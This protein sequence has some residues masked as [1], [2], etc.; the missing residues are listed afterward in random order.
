LSLEAWVAL[1]AVDVASDARESP[2]VAFYRGN[3][4]VDN[5]SRGCSAA[6]TSD[7][8]PR[9]LEWLRLPGDLE[10]IVLGAVPIALAMCRGYVALW[11]R[12]DLAVTAKTVS[13]E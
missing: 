7:P 4:H 13:A 9:L 5:A 11:T 3:G 6:Y 2:Q 12:R 10:F 8:R 1:V